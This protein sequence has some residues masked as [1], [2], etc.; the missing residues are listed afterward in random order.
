MN[1]I[2]T[3]ALNSQSDSMLKDRELFLIFLQ[4]RNAGI[5]LSDC[6]LELRKVTQ[7]ASNVSNNSFSLFEKSYL[8]NRFKFVDFFTILKMPNEKFHKFERKFQFFFWI[9]F[10]KVD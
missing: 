8:C 5:L 6:S 7:S 3:L 4:L 1:S 10:S 2:R 9:L